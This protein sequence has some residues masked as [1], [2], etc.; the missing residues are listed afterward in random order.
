MTA[1]PKKEAAPAAMQF[2]L[3]DFKEVLGFR[4]FAFEGIA[5][6]RSRTAFTVKTDLALTRRY[7]IGLQ[8]L[9]LL[10]REVLERRS[11]TDEPRAYIFG[12]EDMAEHASRAAA[13]H[14][15]AKRK[16]PPRP[17]TTEKTG[18]A[19]RAPAH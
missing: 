17:P 4:V 15:A 6:D 13:R 7:H 18:S 11:E 1:S 2:V 14:E 16:R 19:W 3:K 5:A 8:E 9:P 10:C 12:E